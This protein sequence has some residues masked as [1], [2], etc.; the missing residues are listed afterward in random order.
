MDIEKLSEI[1]SKN[2]EIKKLK[3]DIRLIQNLEDSNFILQRTGSSRSITLNE[4]EQ[5]L[6]RTI[7]L[8]NRVMELEKLKK[9]FAEM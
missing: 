7:V 3:E 6:I 1:N 4:Y 8:T 2:A 5:K 9:E